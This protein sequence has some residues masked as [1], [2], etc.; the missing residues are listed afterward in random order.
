LPGFDS[1][2]KAVNIVKKS[3]LLIRFRPQSQVS[4]ASADSIKESCQR[5]LLLLWYPVTH[6]EKQQGVSITSS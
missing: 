5:L 6:N 2:R 1:L 3:M 4:P